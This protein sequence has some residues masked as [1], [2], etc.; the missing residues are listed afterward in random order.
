MTL[1]LVAARRTH[2][3]LAAPMVM[4]PTVVARE[5]RVGGACCPWRAWRCPRS[6][7]SLCLGQCFRKFFVRRCE[8]GDQGSEG[9]VG[10]H[11]LLEDSC[12]VGHRKGQVVECCAQVVDGCGGGRDCGIS[13]TQRFIPPRSLQLTL[14]FEVGKMEGNL[15][16]SPRVVNGR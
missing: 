3:M 8:R 2:V 15:P 13:A 5:R 7:V 9:Q 4:S 16:G 1:G 6:R 14:A 11:E 12:V 10:R